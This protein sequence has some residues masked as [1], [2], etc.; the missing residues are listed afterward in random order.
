M[1]VE[2]FQTLQSS[3]CSQLVEDTS[4][5]VLSIAGSGYGIAVTGGASMVIGGKGIGVVVCSCTCDM[6]ETVVGGRRVVAGATKGVSGIGV[7]TEGS[8]ITEIGTI[9]MDGDWICDI[10]C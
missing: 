9:S 8:E 5:S 4:V 3:P 1:G 10:S 2:S 6:E 7:R